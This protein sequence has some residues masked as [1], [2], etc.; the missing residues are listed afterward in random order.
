M[1]SGTAN[2]PKCGTHQRFD[3]PA[4]RVAFLAVCGRCGHKF[5]A[6]VMK[7]R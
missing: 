2:C 6:K 1:L 5:A 4:W 7:R 3:F